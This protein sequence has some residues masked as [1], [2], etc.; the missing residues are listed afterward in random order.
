MK[1]RWLLICFLLAGELVVWQRISWL[2]DS[3]L[4]VYFLDVGQGDAIL[5]KSPSGRLVLI[6]GGP[7]KNILPTLAAVLPFGWSKLDLLIE[8]HPDTDHVGGLPDV[9]AQFSV[10]GLLKPCLDEVANVYDQTL[11]TRIFEQDQPVICGAAGE[12]VNLGRGVTL[13]VL[14]AGSGLRP[15][16]N[17]ASVVTRLHYGQTNFLLMGDATMAE[18]KYLLYTVSEKL[19]ADVYKVSHHGSRESNDVDFLRVVQPSLAVIS[20]GAQNRYGHPHTEVLDLLTALG[21]QIKR[22]DQ[23]GTV[24]VVSDGQQVFLAN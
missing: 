18:E 6:D 1:W 12:Q 23:L 5:I 17:G 8:T 20:V 24:T 19:P 10:F 3:R 22:T 11:T 14:A 9:T 15:D 21:S 13:E 7:G 2:T 16:T 4:L